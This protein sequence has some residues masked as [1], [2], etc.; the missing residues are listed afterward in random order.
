MV[1]TEPLKT[2]IKKETRTIERVENLSNILVLLEDFSLSRLACKYLGDQ[3]LGITKPGGI[4]VE[5][6]NMGGFASFL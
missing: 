5:L 1:A 6:F 4:S 2:P 3:T